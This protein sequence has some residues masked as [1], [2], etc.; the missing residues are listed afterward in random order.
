MV[1]VSSKLSSLRTAHARAM[2][3]LP[4]AVAQ[5]A[6]S[7][8]AS[9]S[10][11]SH[12][13]EIF[14]GKGP[15]FSTAVIAGVMAAKNTASLIPFCH[16]VALEDCSIRISMRDETCDDTDRSS[17]SNGLDAGSN[18]MHVQIDCHVKTSNKTGVEMEA[19]VGA[20]SAALCI[21][22]MLKAAS[23]DIRIGEVMLME[24]TGGKSAFLR[25]QQ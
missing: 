13:R 15:V 16:P 5:L 19:L 22:D 18:V 12:A 25:K 20:T 6:E 8:I 1:D 10:K 17:E 24:K 4:R 2:I 3:H 11:D 9:L 14:G 23:H 7:S 21:Y